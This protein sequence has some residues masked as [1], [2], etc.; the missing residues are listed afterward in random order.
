MT[1]IALYLPMQTYAQVLVDFTQSH[2]LEKVLSSGIKVRELPLSGTARQF[3]LYSQNVI[4]RLPGGQDIQANVDDGWMEAQENGKLIMFYFSGPIVPTSEA[5]EVASSVHRAFGIPLERLDNW[6]KNVEG[7]SRGAPK[8]TNGQRNYYPNV[9]VEILS[10]MNSIYP[11]HLRVELSW[12]VEK[13]DK[14][15]EA[16][17]AAHNVRP[18]QGLERVSIDAPSGKTYSRKD[19]N[20]P[21]LK[22]QEELDRRLGQ[23][24][25]A[26][27]FLVKPSPV[28]QVNDEP[29]KPA[30]E[31][32]LEPKPESVITQRVEPP[33]NGWIAWTVAVIGVISGLWLWFKKRK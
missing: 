12:N 3:S 15:D 20:V 1:A 7:K 2:E 11:W 28:P 19:A 4:I 16:W 24:R 26:N 29:P 31:S 23:V 9:F 25:D 6:R 18:P 14:R 30:P 8:Y 13:D 32:K 22:A 21:L 17:G 33:S 5:Y 27:G 10:S